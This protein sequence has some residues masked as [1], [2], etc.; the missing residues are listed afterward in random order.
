MKLV[1]ELEINVVNGSDYVGATVTPHGQNY[2]ELVLT[3]KGGLGNKEAL[4]SATSRAAKCLGIEKSG[5]IKAGFRADLVVA[6]GN[7]LE[8]MESLAPQNIR[9]VMKGGS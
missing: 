7:P 3:S 8:N 2:R 6:M 4:I 5:Q 9:Y 1:K